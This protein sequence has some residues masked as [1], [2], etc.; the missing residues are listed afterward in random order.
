V[1]KDDNPGVQG[2]PALVRRNPKMQ[3][4]LR[5]GKKEETLGRA[6]GVKRTGRSLLF[7]IL[8]FALIAASSLAYTWERQVVETMLIENLLLERR[9]T[10]IQRRAEKL[11]FEV[12]G[13]ESLGRIRQVA[14]AELGMADLDWDDVIVIESKGARSR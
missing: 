9:L 4:P 11:T 2:R 14:K 6:K 13:L 1:I 3:A 10:L 7:G 12:T 5:K 8:L